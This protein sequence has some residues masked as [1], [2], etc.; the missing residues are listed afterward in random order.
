MKSQ[1]SKRQ[2]KLREAF[3][4]F[5]L[6]LVAV[7]QVQAQ[8]ILSSE[9]FPTQFNTAFSP[10]I[11]NGTFTGSSG[12]WTIKSNANASQGIVL[13]FYSP[14]SSYALRICNWRTDGANPS[15]SAPGV[16]YATA[17]SPV[18][19]LSNPCCANGLVMQ[20]TLW[21]YNVVSGDVNA[22][23]AIDFSADGGTTW[24]ATFQKTSAQLFIDYGANTKVTL[25]LTVGAAYNV[26]NFRYRFRSESN[27]NN[28]NNFYVFVDDISFFSPTSTECNPLKL[29]NLV[30]LDASNNGSMDVGE[31]GLA[32]VPIDLYDSVGT[33]IQSTLSDTNGYYQFN[34]LS[35]GAFSEGAILI[36]GF[37]NG[38]VGYL[39]P[40]TDNK[41]DATYTMNGAA[42]TANFLLTT[43]STFID[44]GFKNE[45][46]L[47]PVSII[48]FDGNLIGNRAK[49][50][51]IVEQEKNIVQ[52]DVERSFDGMH[53]MK[54]G[55]VMAL[56][57]KLLNMYDFK[58]EIENNYS[59]KVCYRLKIYSKDG[60]PKYSE[61]ISF[62]ILL[63]TT[64]V[65][66]P[67][68]VRN[69]CTL[70]MKCSKNQV[71]PLTITDINGKMVVMTSVVLS[72]GLNNI[73]LD[74]ISNLS[75]GTYVVQLF[76][77]EEKLKTQ[78][79]IAH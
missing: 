18:I 2:I 60:K 50:Y 75:N 16:G 21:T 77:E 22:K 68:P 13:P 37:A 33:I 79:I 34:N 11:N 7:S 41:N 59:N 12:T 30:W 19:D 29:G 63:P 54:A 32:G 6:L 39:N 52:Y 66:K 8:C 49:I 9:N 35:A 62:S 46:N 76:T 20:M 24:V 42:R 38:D 55:T 43:S 65:I 71:A 56:N 78:L 44:I 17:T 69:T 74:E 36:N 67:N 27:K 23:L 51:W 1:Y 5:V 40:L 31:Q 57:K 48:S 15:P 4:P 14:S 73:S 25:T 72:K 26:S 61:V 3:L 58:E 64:L 10:N 53:F 70:T 45:V 47:L 28:N